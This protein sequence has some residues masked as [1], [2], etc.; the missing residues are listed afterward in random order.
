MPYETGPHLSLGPRLQVLHELQQSR[1]SQAIQN[2]KKVADHKVLQA[3]AAVQAQFSLE[4]K[5]TAVELFYPI[6]TEPRGSGSQHSDMHTSFR[7]IIIEELFPWRV[8]LFSLK[9]NKNEKGKEAIFS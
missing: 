3:H 8:F 9:K 2:G 4:S 5:T 7:V 6:N 1:V